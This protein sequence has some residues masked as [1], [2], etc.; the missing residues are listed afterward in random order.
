MPGYRQPWPK[1]NRLWILVGPYNGRRKTRGVPVTHKGTSKACCSGG[2]TAFAHLVSRERFEVHAI[3]AHV[4]DGLNVS[5][6][7]ASGVQVQH[8]ETVRQAVRRRGK[9]ANARTEKESEFR[10][11]HARRYKNREGDCGHSS[12]LH[13]IVRGRTTVTC[14]RP[15]EEGSAT[16]VTYGRTQ[17]RVR[18]G[19]DVQAGTRPRPRRDLRPCCRGAGSATGNGQRCSLPNVRRRSPSHLACH[20]RRRDPSNGLPGG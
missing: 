4:L 6:H 2:R 11:R 17:T 20:S 19:Q 3:R 8:L 7:L 14:L 15:H 13:P 10:Y 18:R 12:P 16:P 5:Q 1:S 9:E